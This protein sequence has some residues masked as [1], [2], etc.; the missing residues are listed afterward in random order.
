MLQRTQPASI[1][2]AGTLALT[3]ILLSAALTLTVAYP[4][5]MFLKRSQDHNINS[6]SSLHLGL[7]FLC[8]E[9]P[10]SMGTFSRQ[11]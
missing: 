7:P 11:T 6:C 1:P 5:H 8:L 9:G 3:Q 2:A 10:L 4:T